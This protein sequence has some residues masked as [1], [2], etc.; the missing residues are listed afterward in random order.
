MN[1]NNSSAIGGRSRRCYFVFFMLSFDIVVAMDNALPHMLTRADLEKAVRIFVGRLRDGGLFVASIRD[2]DR[3]LQEKPAPSA[4]YVH[5]TENGQR[6]LFQ[7]WD[8]VGENYRFIQYIIDG[9]ASLQI[10][11]FECEY[12]AT[13]REEI[14]K[15]LYACGCREVFWKLLEITGFYQPV[16]IVRK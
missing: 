12:P 4:P 2:Y 10:S 7:T 13:R 8:W 15:L 9:G 6:V 11:K 3:M 5:K 1:P 14:S 16:V